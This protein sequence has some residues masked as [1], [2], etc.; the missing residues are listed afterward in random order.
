MDFN[1][2]SC[3]TCIG[4]GVLQVYTMS[5][6]PVVMWLLRYTVVYKCDTVAALPL[7][8]YRGHIQFPVVSEDFNEVVHAHTF[9]VCLFLV[10]LH[11]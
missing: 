8:M 7:R 11:E 6:L 2:T 5:F 1:W 9:H 4:L 10:Y 3:T